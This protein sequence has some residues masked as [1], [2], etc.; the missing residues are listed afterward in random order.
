M[1]GDST[2]RGSCVLV[3]TQRTATRI[4]DRRRDRSMPLCVSARSANRA[5]RLN[6]LPRKRAVRNSRVR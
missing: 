6:P 3:A 4:A 2:I 5:A 1:V